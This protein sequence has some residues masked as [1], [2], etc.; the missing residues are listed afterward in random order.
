MRQIDL[1][2]KT[3][4]TNW[5]GG[6]FSRADKKEN[7]QERI[8][9]RFPSFRQRRVPINQRPPHAI[10]NEV[11][12]QL[13]AANCLK[14]KQSSTLQNDCSKF[15]E[16]RQLRRRTEANVTVRAIMLCVLI[17]MSS[18]FSASSTKHVEFPFKHKHNNYSYACTCWD[19]SE[20]SETI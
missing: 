6:G 18:S 12:V 7:L 13:R 17:S 8:H 10:H 9:G 11:T 15:E 14:T 4:T 20:V 1:V 3:I 2:P 16:K 19:I 5:Q